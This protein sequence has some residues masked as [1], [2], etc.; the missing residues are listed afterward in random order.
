MFLLIILSVK[1]TKDVVEVCHV[2]LR[3]ESLLRIQEVDPR[4][5]TTTYLIN[6]RLV[7]D[8][9]PKLQPIKGAERILLV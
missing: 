5:E 9:P 7:K 1:D 3:E 4:D 2:K 6:T 8:L